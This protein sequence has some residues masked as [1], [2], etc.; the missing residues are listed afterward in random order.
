MIRAGFDKIPRRYQGRYPSVLFGRGCN[1]CA[2]NHFVLVN[3]AMTMGWPW[4]TIF[5]SDAYPLKNCRD[6][7]GEF[8]GSTGVPKDADEIIYG[9][10]HFIR[11]YTYGG[12]NNFCLVDVGEGYGHIKHDLWGAHAVTIFKQGYERWINNYL[13][14]STQINADFFMWLTPNCY[15]TT[16]SFFLQKKK[17]LQCPDKL[18]D[19]QYLCEYLDEK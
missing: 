2:L 12:K 11:D 8:L 4:V 16:R 18:I 7:L 3:M 19:K 17:E 10:L 5:E 15:A 6:Q 14:Q 13:K 9:N 1:V